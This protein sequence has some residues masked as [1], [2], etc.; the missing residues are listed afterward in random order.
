M[1]NP[2]GTWEILF[3]TNG[4]LGKSCLFLSDWN[5][6]SSFALSSVLGVYLSSFIV[7]DAPFNISLL[8]NIF[9]FIYAIKIRIYN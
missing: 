1:D 7:G 2:D 8:S 3:K 6:P 5:S 4:L 9:L